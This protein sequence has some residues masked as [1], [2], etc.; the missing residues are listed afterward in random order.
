VHGT[1][2]PHD[3]ASA[4]AGMP[5]HQIRARISINL[6]AIQTIIRQ[7]QQAIEEAREALRNADEIL[8][9]AGDVG[10]TCNGAAAEPCALQRRIDKTP[11]WG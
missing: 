6:A 9:G 3:E 7:S 2:N 1:I 8:A 5:L 10:T 4:L 11:R